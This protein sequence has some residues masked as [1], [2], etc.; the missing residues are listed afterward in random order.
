MNKSDDKKDLDAMIV[1]AIQNKANSL[2]GMD[3]T[4]VLIQVVT[5]PFAREDGGIVSTEAY[6][7]ETGERIDNPPE[8]PGYLTRTIT[9]TVQEKVP[10]RS[11][12]QSFG[13]VSRVVEFMTIKV[14]MLGVKKVKDAYDCLQAAIWGVQKYYRVTNQNNIF[15]KEPEY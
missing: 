12:D 15:I 4:G 5:D 9:M 13:S 8:F 3:K 6:S 10:L 11:V 7:L 1:E 14:S 2:P